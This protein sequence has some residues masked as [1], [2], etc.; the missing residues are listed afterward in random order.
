MDEWSRSVADACR[1]QDD[2]LS[3]P[4]QGEYEKDKG[5]QTA[6]HR[7]IN[8]FGEWVYCK[9]CRVIIFRDNLD[10]VKVIARGLG[11]W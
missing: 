6:C 9:Y 11:M 3:A 1:V 7:Q 10:G 8:D 2:Q 4:V 5:A